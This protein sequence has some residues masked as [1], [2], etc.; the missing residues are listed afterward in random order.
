[1]L[2]YEPPRCD[3]DPV[4]VPGRGLALG[5]KG[6]NAPHGVSVEVVNLAGDLLG[7]EVLGV[8]EYR[9][10][11]DSRSLHAPCARNFAG[12]PFNIRAGRPVDHE[13]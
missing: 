13:G 1:M 3:P 5:C 12:G 7:G 9:L 11:R 8:V 4:T 10:H 6:Q 2:S